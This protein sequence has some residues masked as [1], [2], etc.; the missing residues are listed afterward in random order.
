[1]ETSLSEMGKAVGDPVRAA[2]LA[3]LMDGE[4]RPAGELAYIGN[5]SAQ[6]A[7]FHIAKLLSAGLI[8]VHRQGRRHYYRLSSEDV[9]HVLE[10]MASVSGETRK[11][12]QVDAALVFARSCYKHLAGKVAVEIYRALTL[13][14]FVAE[15]GSRDAQ[16][17][18]DG[19][20]WLASVAGQEVKPPAGR[21]CLD[22]TERR[23]HLGG[24]LGVLLFSTLKQARWVAQSPGT[25]CVRVTHLGME[26]LER[27][28]GVNSA[29]VL[30]AMRRQTR[31]D[32]AATQR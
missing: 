14:G 1:M 12:K 24:P 25:R 29:A 31:S 23:A 32:A 11:L 30:S 7:S 9:A 5:V 6:T 17:T 22:W 27:E 19:A 16:L 4:T 15:S 3:A 10:A 13:R 28:L 26:K 2:M 20:S 21:Q 18:H 8:A